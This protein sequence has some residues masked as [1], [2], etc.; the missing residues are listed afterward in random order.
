[1][2]YIFVLLCTSRTLARSLQLCCCCR[3]CSLPAR[4]VHTEHRP[5]PEEVRH[6][7]VGHHHHSVPHWGE[8]F[9][10]GDVGMHPRAVGEASRGLDDA[11]RAKLAHGVLSSWRDPVA[12]QLSY[13]HEHRAIV[14]VRVL[15]LLS[16]H[17]LG[18]GR[19]SASQQ[20]EDPLCCLGTTCCS[21]CVGGDLALAELSSLHLTPK[22]VAAFKRPRRSLVRPVTGA[23]QLCERPVGLRNWH[24]R[25]DEPD[26]AR[27]PPREVQG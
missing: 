23:E 26:H 20:R 3:H 25:T 16:Q 12:S 15:L 7:M 27:L 21:H 4:L 22:P 8:V 19:A 13:E 6:A 2:R 9:P 11:D 1:M 10:G 24:M 5:R 17:G 14:Q 18:F